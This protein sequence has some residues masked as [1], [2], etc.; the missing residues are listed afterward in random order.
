MSRPFKFPMFLTATPGEMFFA[1]SAYTT[2]SSLRVM[3]STYGKNRGLAF[4]IESFVQDVR[5]GRFGWVVRCYDPKDPNL[6]R[7]SRALEYKGPKAD[8]LVQKLSEAAMAQEQDRAAALA[9]RTR[10]A[11]LVN[12]DDPEGTVPRRERSALER[13]RWMAN[14]RAHTHELS[15]ALQ[16]AAT[17]TSHRTY[18]KPLAYVQI[19]DRRLSWMA[20]WFSEQ[21]RKPVPD[22]NMFARALAAKACA[23]AG[24]PPDTLQVVRL[25]ITPKAP[26]FEFR[27]PA[28]DPMQAKVRPRAKR[29]AKVHAVPPTV[30]LDVAITQH[31][32]KIRAANEFDDALRAASEKSV[33]MR[34]REQMAAAAAPVLPADLFDP[35]DTA[36]QPAGVPHTSEPVDAPTQALAPRAVPATPEGGIDI[37]ALVGL[38]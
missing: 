30:D 23:S 36:E 2:E 10:G 17:A 22:L 3:C 12:T 13:A 24:V 1:N 11:S 16:Q 8:E 28:F 6:A 21:T 26:G 9:Q 15:M 34:R 14:A 37:D 33:E 18:D 38:R 4:R 27:G 7:R 35:V 20:Q 29:T 32:A 25:K 5:N 19:T 31:N